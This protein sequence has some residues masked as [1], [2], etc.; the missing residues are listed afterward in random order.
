MALLDAPSLRPVAATVVPALTRSARNT[1]HTAA[2]AS[3]T[4]PLA[5]CSD[6]GFAPI[7]SAPGRKLPSTR[8]IAPWTAAEAPL[9]PPARSNR[10]PARSNRLPEAPYRS[11]AASIRPPEAPWP[12]LHCFVDRSGSSVARTGSSE[13]PFSDTPRH[14]GDESTTD[15]GPGWLPTT[16]SSTKS[17]TRTCLCVPTAHTFS[18]SEGAV[19]TRASLGVIGG[20]AHVWLSTSAP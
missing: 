13:S 3:L 17:F 14:A 4:L 20:F 6:P 12:L 8:P 15:F 1:P 7:P 9:Y 11:P 19:R 18:F 10:S 16:Q 2:V 5:R